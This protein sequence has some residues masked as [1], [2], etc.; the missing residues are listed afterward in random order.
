MT[1]AITPKSMAHQWRRPVCAIIENSLGLVMA[2]SA[3]SLPCPLMAHQWRNQASRAP[4]TARYAPPALCLRRRSE[5]HR[6]QH[7]RIAF[8]HDQHLQHHDA[9]GGGSCQKDLVGS[10]HALGLVPCPGLILQGHRECLNPKF[11]AQQSLPL[12]ACLAIGVDLTHIFARTQSEAPRWER[13][14][15]MAALRNAL[16]EA[17]PSETRE[18]WRNLYIG[19][20]KDRGRWGGWAG[21]RRRAAYPTYAFS[22]AAPVQKILVRLRQKIRAALGCRFPGQRDSGAW[23]FRLSATG[24]RADGKTHQRLSYCV[25]LGKRCRA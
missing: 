14:G 19:R 5:A 25:W 8:M 11:G 4:R 9:T 18:C 7:A 20:Q 23:L 10:N 2:Q 16:A 1:C 22:F 12:P 24:G 17:M 13:H 3:P 6:Y 15:K 21:K